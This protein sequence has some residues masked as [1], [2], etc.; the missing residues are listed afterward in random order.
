MARKTKSNDAPPVVDNEQLGNSAEALFNAE[1]LFDPE[2]LLNSEVLFDGL[3]QTEDEFYDRDPFSADYVLFRRSQSAVAREKRARVN[4][5]MR[6][7]MLEHPHLLDNPAEASNRGAAAIW[8]SLRDLLRNESKE[9]IDT[10]SLEELMLLKRDLETRK[11]V[12]EAV[13]TGLEHQLKRLEQRLSV[14]DPEQTQIMPAKINI[15]KS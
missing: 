8:R 5:N 13:N 10:S 1:D 11:A 12:V 9:L 2:S 15:K 4:E 7:D 14:H 6:K 3:P